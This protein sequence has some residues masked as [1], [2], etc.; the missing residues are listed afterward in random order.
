MDL[1]ERLLKYMRSQSAGTL[2]ARFFKKYQLSED[3][4]EE[5]PQS[6]WAVF[7]AALQFLSEG[8]QT[9]VNSH[10][11][12][13]EYAVIL[14][15]FHRFQNKQSKEYGYRDL[16][17]SDLIGSLPCSVRK[18][19]STIVDPDE[20]F[21]SITLYLEAFELRELSE[22]FSVGRMA[23]F[24]IYQEISDIYDERK[25]W[26]ELNNSNIELQTNGDEK[27]NEPGDG[28]SNDGPENGRHKSQSHEEH[29]EPQLQK[30]DSAD[31]NKESR[32]QKQIIYVEP[33]INECLGA[34]R[35]LETQFKLYLSFINGYIASNPC[36]IRPLKN[37]DT[38]DKECWEHSIR[39]HFKTDRKIYSF[40]K[41][42]FFKKPKLAA[43]DLD[44]ANSWLVREWEQQKLKETNE[45]SNDIYDQLSL[46]DLIIEGFKNAKSRD[47]NVNS[48]FFSEFIELFG[49]HPHD[50]I[51]SE[52]CIGAT[53]VEN[54]RELYFVEAGLEILARRFG[55]YFSYVNESPKGSDS[56]YARIHEL[57]PMWMFEHLE[58]I[59]WKRFNSI[60]RG[61][62]ERKEVDSALREDV[63]TFGVNSEEISEFMKRVYCCEFIRPVYIQLL[64]SNLYQLIDRK[65][66]LPWPGYLQKYSDE[67]WDAVKNWFPN[68]G[69]KPFQ[70]P[71]KQTREK[72]LENFNR[73]RGKLLRFLK[74]NRNLDV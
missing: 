23:F 67:D 1:K 71:D 57:K 8:N 27:D 53:A 60:R 47:K 13:S 32:D 68:F 22:N 24:E 30:E 14:E 65:S 45:D 38:A 20:V 5:R 40:Y 64:H 73:T 42:N 19:E 69:M 35:N 29:S 4:L 48:Q 50:S 55:G 12:N 58:S 6:F 26:F 44:D 39:Y 66:S 54:T 11:L 31:S 62:D 21:L 2:A 28:Q 56:T 72:F 37:I 70:L 9:R 10:E 16:S 25:R 15:H 49:S 52:L 33:S 17:L 43:L 63:D 59:E 7:L 34:L 46:D 51:A 36:S 41:E 3:V 18:H 61:L 74:E